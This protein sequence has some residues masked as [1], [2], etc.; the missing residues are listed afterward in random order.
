MAEVVTAV[1]SV[2]VLAQVRGWKTSE[3]VI[4]VLEMRVVREE[5]TL[6][7]RVSFLQAEDGIRVRYVT[8]VQAG[9]LPISVAETKLVPAGIASDRLTPVASDGPLFVTVSV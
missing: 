7:T 1:S 9:A 4:P 3:S 5:S 2:G 6:T 8:R